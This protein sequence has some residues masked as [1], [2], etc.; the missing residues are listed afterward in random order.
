MKNTGNTI[1]I[2]GGS[3][4]FGREYARAWHDAG[5]TVIVAARSEDE[6]EET[7]EGREN[8]HAMP[9]DVADAS[10]VDR[11]AKEVVE[12]FPDLNIVMN[13]AGIMPYE[14][15]TG[16]RDLSDAEKVIAINVL[17]PIRLTDALIDHLKAQDDAVLINVTSGL[18]YVPMPKAATYSATK[19][20]MH[21][22][23][24]SLRKLLEGQVEVIE[25]VPPGVQTELTPGQSTREG[26]MP[27]D[28]FI[29]ETLALFAQNPTPEEILV[30]RVKG[31]R[32][33][34]RD[35]TVKENLDMVAKR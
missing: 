11:F 33:A 19:A 30:E 29:E 26:Y 13:N 23:T 32:F 24:L 27:L 16:A 18:A 9:L 4:G 14:D 3:S 6:L 28:E 1:L 15:I 20:A 5:N 21:S 7:A 17:G 12:H 10:A 35:G 8:L 31:F 22:Y 34:E 2:T 25:L